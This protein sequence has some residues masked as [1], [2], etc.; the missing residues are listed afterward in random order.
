MEEA[1][2]VAVVEARRGPIWLDDESVQALAKLAFSDQERL[3]AA[4]GL[5]FFGPSSLK[6]LP[7]LRHLARDGDAEVRRMVVWAVNWS[8]LPEGLPVLLS[9]LEDQDP[10]V[11]TSASEGL[12]SHFDS[13]EK[14]RQAM[15]NWVVR[16]H[17]AEILTKF[18]P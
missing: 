3:F 9:L 2:S 15:L 6:T 8:G 7:I 1:A 18:K 4:G 10:G 13:A 14:S 11:R 16:L 17:A 12:K 5:G